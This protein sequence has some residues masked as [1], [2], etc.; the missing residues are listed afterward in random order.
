[1]LSSQAVGGESDLWPYA[2]WRM[3]RRL[4]GSG[5]VKGTEP[6][7]A[8]AKASLNRAIVTAYGP[9]PGWSI[10]DQDEA[11]KKPEMSS[12]EIGKRGPKNN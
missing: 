1:M 5:L 6:T 3:S 2:Y 9:E 7:R 11:W 4:I 12:T 8:I 10:H